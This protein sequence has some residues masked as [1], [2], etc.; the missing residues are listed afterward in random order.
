MPLRHTPVLAFILAVLACL[1]TSAQ[2]D[3]AQ[4]F[5]IKLALVRSEWP[6]KGQDDADLQAE[7]KD[8][9][10]TEVVPEQ[11]RDDLLASAS[12][13]LFSQDS[14]AVYERDDFEMMFDWL[15]QHDLIR[16]EVGRTS[17][18]TSCS[19][20]VSGDVVPVPS[21]PSKD[22]ATAPASSTLG[23]D[24]FF[25][26]QKQSEDRKTIEIHLTRALQR[27]HEVVE[28]GSE[29]VFHEPL[30]SWPFKFEIPSG[31]V[32][33]VHALA[34]AGSAHSPE[35]AGLPELARKN[36]WDPILLIKTPTQGLYAAHSDPR[37]SKP[38]SVQEITAFPPSRHQSA[39]A[40]RKEQSA[41]T[42]SS[43]PTA[44]PTPVTVQLFMVRSDWSK[45]ENVENLNSQLGEFLED[46][47]VPSSLRADLPRAAPAVL[48]PKDQLAAYRPDEF[49]A[50]MAWMKQ[51][52]LAL[53][54][55]IDRLPFPETLPA[56]GPN[57]HY[58]RLFVDHLH[59]PLPI[60]RRND[61][62]TSR[63]H[64][65]QWYFRTREEQDGNEIAKLAV[66]VWRSPYRPEIEDGNWAPSFT[67]F[68]VPSVFRFTMPA[69]HVVVMNSTCVPPTSR[70]QWWMLPREL[71]PEG[72]IPVFVLTPARLGIAEPETPKLSAPASLI[73]IVETSEADALAREADTGKSSRF[74]SE[75]VRA[76][77]G[78]PATTKSDSDPAAITVELLRIRS[79]WSKAKDPEAAGKALETLVD[80]V[81]LPD[82]IRNNL[83]GSATQI[84]CP[85]GFIASYRPQ[86][87]LD[88]L[89]WLI[90]QD[91]AQTHAQ[92]KPIPLWGVRDDRTYAEIHMCGLFIAEDVVP[93]SP[94]RERSDAP[95][96]FNR[97]YGWKWDFVS[98]LKEE[99]STEQPSINVRVDLFQAVRDEPQLDGE[100]PMIRAGQAGRSLEGTFP[101]RQVGIRRCFQRLDLDDATKQAIQG[102]GW[103]PLLVIFP[104][105]LRVER[106]SSPPQLRKP[107]SLQKLALCIDEMPGT[108][109]SESNLLQTDE[110]SAEVPKPNPQ[111]RIYI[112]KHAR[113][114]QLAPLLLSVMPSARITPNKPNNSL[115]VAAAQDQFETLEDL[116]KRLDTS[117]PPQQPRAESADSRSIETTRND[118]NTKQKEAASLAR[119]LATETDEKAARQLRSRLTRLITEAFN[120]RQKLQRAE[121]ALLEERIRLVE[122]RLEQRE[123]LRDEIIDHRV[124]A[125]LAND[126]TFDSD[127]H[128]NVRAQPGPT[129]AESTAPQPTAVGHTRIQTDV[130]WISDDIIRYLVKEDRIADWG[131]AYRQQKLRNPW[132]PSLS[133]RFH[134]CL[135]T[136]GPNDAIPN[137]FL[138]EYQEFVKHQAPNLDQIIDRRR[139]KKINE[140]TGTRSGYGTETRQPEMEGTVEWAGA[141]YARIQTGFYWAT[142]PLSVEVRLAQED[143]WCYEALLRSIA[144]TNEDADES[145]FPN[146]PVLRIRTLAIGQPA[147]KAM[148]ALRPN[149]A[150]L[151]YFGTTQKPTEAGG[152]TDAQLGIVP[153]PPD[154]PTTPPS[155]APEEVAKRLLTG[156]YVDFTGAPLEA[157]TKPY[158]EFNLLPVHLVVDVFES[159][160]P[161]LLSQLANSNM[162]L[163]V[164]YIATKAPAT[165]GPAE[166][167]NEVPRRVRADILGLI[168][169]FNPPDINKLDASVVQSGTPQDTLVRMSFQNRPWGDVLKWLA[170]VHG[171]K[172]MTMTIPEGTFDFISS[173]PM[174]LADAWD[175][176]AR[177]LRIDGYLL[178]DDIDG[179]DGRR[180]LWTKTADS[181]TMMRQANEAVEDIAKWE[182]ALAEEDRQDDEAYLSTVQK[183]LDGARQWAASLRQQ[184]ALYLNRCLLQ[185][186]ESA[187]TLETARQ[188]LETTKKLLAKGYVT[189]TEQDARTNG[190]AKLVDQH[191]ALEAD[192]DR[193]QATAD[194]LGLTPEDIEKA[195]AEAE[196][197]EQYGMPM[198]ASGQYQQPLAT[199]G[200]APNPS[201][202]QPLTSTERC[203]QEV[204]N[205]IRELEETTN[206]IT[207][208]EE[209]GDAK[210]AE[211]LR[212]HLPDFQASL[213]GSLAP[214]QMEITH[215]GGK[216]LEY[217]AAVPLALEAL[218]EARRFQEQG[219]KTPT[220][221]TEANRRYEQ[222]KKRVTYT[223][224]TI[225]DL[226]KLHDSVDWQSLPGAGPHK[227]APQTPAPTTPKTSTATP[228]IER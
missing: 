39:V 113:A 138:D 98:S 56:D 49:A 26:P 128:A 114:D 195:K 59:M 51:R 163:D 46:V 204:T 31:K 226:Q 33:V 43:P 89:T 116:I 222:A 118:Y 193:F 64:G 119:S 140:Q 165:E 55:E 216:L 192:I 66:D 215:L 187:A 125:L 112:L 130:S 170:D 12:Q 92:S 205:R 60:G 223:K 158:P 167:S 197:V 95:P 210:E 50:A 24:W 199:L 37:L 53:P 44:N 145:T 18:F 149:R 174:S 196:K 8:L 23:W 213:A 186:Q 38:Q 25:Q 155:R 148:Q 79:D 133:P 152:E 1:F 85:E 4:P 82:K 168:R 47:A 131:D 176:V 88:M 184:I 22:S 146:V 134:Q 209:R 180:A 127:G 70:N 201:T 77:V 107:L 175:M 97:T 200:P 14:L 76:S 48:F 164:T 157:H 65:W 36:G 188:D 78:P 34:L 63:S 28:D 84:L 123:T 169:I 166:D 15:K 217:E 143:L 19:F 11:F 74:G 75:D 122:S 41:A 93:V 225:D 159:H 141:D 90:D 100:P 224:Q 178:H 108:R 182:K 150:H 211:T 151:A 219:L 104:A 110:S 117:P 7:L 91:L 105:G 80:G 45:G 129:L 177:K 207:A 172:W 29:A 190:V 16:V 156:R 69:D 83:L 102:Q 61:S 154:A 52:K 183:R 198:Q 227:P 221:V 142:R 144:Q 73:A 162:P 228:G 202:S 185:Q 68:Y 57:T 3:A 58:Q 218:N 103:D 6:E 10:K 87:Y 96:F 189:K 139:P 203:R 181:R 214:L 101:A 5:E 137:D 86:E 2:S 111:L 208:A 121:L 171:F 109:S 40:R 17:H 136:I 62:E 27:R 99:S 67:E 94:T 9:L 13:I 194:A 132:P 160:L 206:A 135:K 20:F 72:W 30:T 81:A 21:P 212:K 147:A 173:E 220:E 153:S 161:V 179:T 106:S 32:G 54:R 115:I 191:A 71:G 124:E 120:L 35:L 126:L 42:A